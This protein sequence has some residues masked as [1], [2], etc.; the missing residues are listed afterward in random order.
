MARH[1]PVVTHADVSAP[2]DRVRCDRF[3]TILTAEA[4]AGRTLAL[5]LKPG[6]VRSGRVMAGTARYAACA[7]CALGAE[8]RVRLALAGQP[9]EPEDLGLARILPDAPSPRAAEPRP[10]T[11]ADEAFLAG[12]GWTPGDGRWLDQHGDAYRPDVALELAKRDRTYVVQNIGKGRR[13][14]VVPTVVGRGRAA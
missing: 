11:P 8:A 4:C 14:A 7:R 9:G 2:A 1:L 12:Q 5:K 6:H 3:S 10:L 13:F